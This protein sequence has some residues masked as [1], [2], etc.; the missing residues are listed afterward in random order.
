VVFEG[1]PDDFIGE[2]IPF[3][4]HFARVYRLNRVVVW[5]KSKLP[6][7]TVKICCTQRVAEAIRIGWM[8]CFKRRNQQIGRIKP[9]AGINGWAVS[10]AEISKLAVSNPWLA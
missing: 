9:L 8:G 4:D 10:S 1:H 2:D 3:L 7:R 5:P 6:P